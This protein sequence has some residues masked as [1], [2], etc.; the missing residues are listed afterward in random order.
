VFGDVIP[1]AVAPGRC[2]FVASDGLL[3]TIAFAVHLED[4]DV[5]GELVEQRAGQAFAS[6]HRR[7]FGKR[8]V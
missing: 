2:G 8:Q 1:I 6:E 4:I 3:E 5:M 7:P